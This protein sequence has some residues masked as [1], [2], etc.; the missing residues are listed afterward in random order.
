MKKL[1]FWILNKLNNQ[2][3]LKLIGTQVLGKFWSHRTSILEIMG[4]KLTISAPK[5][6]WKSQNLS[7][8]LNVHNFWTWIQFL[9]Q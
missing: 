9:I 4:P 1:I 6:Y 5:I 2:K 8:H 7:Q 3:S